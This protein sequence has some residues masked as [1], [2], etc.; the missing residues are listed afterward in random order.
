[1]LAMMQC[2]PR[3]MKINMVQVVQDESVEMVNP[4]LR[5]MQMFTETQDMLPVVMP[6]FKLPITT[7]YQPM[8]MMNDMVWAM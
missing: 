4:L 3:N 6:M 8:D 1:M 5:P 7:E 2:Q